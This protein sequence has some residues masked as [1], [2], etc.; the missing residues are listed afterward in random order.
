MHFGVLV[1][2]YFKGNELLWNIEGRS[3]ASG[4]GQG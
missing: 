2:H 4:I 1:E 3:L